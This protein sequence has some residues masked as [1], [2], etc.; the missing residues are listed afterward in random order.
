[1]RRTSRARVAIAVLAVSAVVSAPLASRA[2]APSDEFRLGWYDSLSN[3]NNPAGIAAD[4]MTMISAYYGYG[5]QPAKYL[6]AAHAA[7]TTVTA[8]IPRTLVKSMDIGRIKAYV[9]LYKD[10]PALEGWSLA[11]EPTVNKELGPLTPA[12]AITIYKAIKSV[13]PVHR[14]SIT[15]ASGEDPKPF[16]P[17]LDVLQHDDYPAKAGTAEFTNLDRWKNFTFSMGYTALTNNKRF[18]PVLQAFGGTN[19][20]PVLGYRAPTANEMRYMAFSSIAALADSMFFWNYYRRDP[21]W[22]SATL[23]PITAELRSMQPALTAGARWGVVSSSTS[24]IT[25]TALQNPS[26]GRWYVVAVNHTPGTVSGTLTFSREL[27]GKT[28]AYSGST[29]TPI[30]ADRLAHALGGYEA[31]IYTID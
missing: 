17:A 4:G 5:S 31:R 21:S 28:L 13:D 8:E 26:T 25:A 20:A 29:P 2:A 1:M 6:A 30:V 15:F 10:K 24:S 16:L 18:I 14:V 23:A 11:D 9:N 3:L 12:N 27:A 7:G 22:V 19:Q